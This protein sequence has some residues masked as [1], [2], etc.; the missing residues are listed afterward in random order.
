MNPRPVLL[1]DAMPIKEAVHLLLEKD[2]SG[3]PVVDAAGKLVG[4]LSESDLI[5]KGAGKVGVFVFV[6]CAHSWGSVVIIT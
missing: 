5:W 4:V 1:S 3:A 6:L 2:V